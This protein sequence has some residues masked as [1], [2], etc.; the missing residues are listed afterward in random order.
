MVQISQVPVMPQPR[1]HEYSIFNNSHPY[2]GE[3]IFNST[4]QVGN[5]SVGSHN[6]L[7]WSSGFTSRIQDSPTVRDGSL[8]SQQGLRTSRIP[9]P[10]RA[11]EVQVSDYD[12]FQ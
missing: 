12:S 6:S 5:Q 4:P 2:Q 3:E 1:G 10:I 9:S 11:P 8:A 7:G